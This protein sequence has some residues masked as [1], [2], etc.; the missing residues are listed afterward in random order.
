MTWKSISS[1][2]IFILSFIGGK[3]AYSAL[4]SESETASFESSDWKKQ[5]D[6]GITYEAPF[7]LSVKE[8]AL[9]ANIKPFVKNLSTYMYDSKAI[10]FMLSKAEYNDDIQTDLNGAVQGA[11]QNISASE[12]VSE[13]KYQTKNC[14][15][16][17]LLGKKIEA[18]LKIKGKEAEMVAELYAA[19]NRLI[20]VMF[21]NLSYTENREIRNKIFNSLR[22]TL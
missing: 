22:V 4:F 12:G 3:L 13:F 14:S 2:L 15:R 10:S 21:T 7:E 8:I 6:L 20:Q 18:T 19:G 16:N 1:I 5:F 17:G 9:P 11:I